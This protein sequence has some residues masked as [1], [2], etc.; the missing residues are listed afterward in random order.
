MNFETWLA[1]VATVGGVALLPGP[2]TLL[3]AAQARALGLRAAFAALGG[4]LLACA[5][6][7]ALVGTGLGQV[8]AA[9][10]GVLDAVRIAGFA[11]LGWIVWRGIA[12]RDAAGGQ[13]AHTPAAALFAQGFL[14]CAA[15]PKLI[16]HLSAFLPLF[17]MPTRPLLP[18]LTLIAATQLI[19]DGLV[20]GAWA[21]AAA[22][23]PAPRHCKPD[24]APA[25]RSCRHQSRQ[26]W[27]WV[28]GV[29]RRCRPG[30]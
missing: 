20:L 27:S 18:Q 24:G 21:L 15:N 3:I 25:D 26:Q 13:P 12:R 23:R 6:M 11:W 17:L 5:M 7:V 16:L 8:F 1:L 10:P 19:I 2:S 28:S 22:K 9:Y 29:P 14:T 30:T 4:D